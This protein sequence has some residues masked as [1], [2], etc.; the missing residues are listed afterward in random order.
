MKN[1]TRSLIPLQ[2][3]KQTYFIHIS[4]TLADAADAEKFKHCVIEYDKKLLEN[5]HETNNK[6]AIKIQDEAFYG[7]ASKKYTIECVACNFLI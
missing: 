2:R 1:S 7:W 4:R 3:S 5:Q 6:K